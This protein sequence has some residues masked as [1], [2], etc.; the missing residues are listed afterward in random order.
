MSKMRWTPAGGMALTTLA[1]G[2]SVVGIPARPAAA[3]I[4]NPLPIRVKLGVLLPQHGDTKRDTGDVHFNAEVDLAL[5]LPGAGSRQVTVGYS[6]SLES[7]KKLR[8]IPV[9]VAQVFSAPNPAAGITGNVYFGLGFGA[10]FLRASGGGVSESKTR[11]GGFGMA[12]YQFPNAFFVEAKYHLVSGKVAG[13]S[14]N[15]LAFLLGRRF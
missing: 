1:V 2:G 9:T 15:G 8:A 4:N 10:Y 14:P 11:L 12:G 5:P 7:G 3:Q 6:Q 13:L